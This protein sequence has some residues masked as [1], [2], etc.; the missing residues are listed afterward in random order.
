MMSDTKP[1]RETFSTGALRDKDDNKSRPDLISPFFEE[2][3]GDLLTKGAK[4]YVV[5]NWEKGMPISRC[6]ASLRRHL[7]QYQQGKT[8]EDHMAAVAF[9][10]MAIIHYEEMIKHGTLSKEFD[11]MP[12]YLPSET[13]APKDSR[14]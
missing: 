7:M 13:D 4:H 9:N 8:D 1:D 6:I 5:R 2:R 11:D 14:R 12:T 10:A 3:L